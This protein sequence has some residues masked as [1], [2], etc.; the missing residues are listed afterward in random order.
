MSHENK[1][2]MRKVTEQTEKSFSAYNIPLFYKSQNW[3]YLIDF[4]FCIY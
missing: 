1:E 2:G 4:T 3:C